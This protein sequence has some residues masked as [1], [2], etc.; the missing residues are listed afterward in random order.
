M[1]KNHIAAALRQNTKDRQRIDKEDPFL[2]RVRR[3]IK[4]K[5]PLFFQVIPISKIESINP[6]QSELTFNCRGRMS[7]TAELKSLGIDTSK[8]SKEIDF[9]SQVD[10]A[11]RLT[12]SDRHG[13]ITLVFIVSRP[14]W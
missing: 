8:E 4:K 14:G 9:D 6:D 1:R 13:V 10:G 7:V 5:W 12:L 11:P 3:A 2:K